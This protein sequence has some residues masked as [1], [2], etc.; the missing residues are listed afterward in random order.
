MGQL[1]LPGQ[2]KLRHL[3]GKVDCLPLCEG[4]V[5]LHVRADKSGDVLEHPEGNRRGRGCGGLF[6]LAE[7]GD[8]ERVVLFEGLEEPLEGLLLLA[9]HLAGVVLLGVNGD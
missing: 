4:A 1:Q 7:K 8:I 6:L 3:G 5:F 9:R 2:E